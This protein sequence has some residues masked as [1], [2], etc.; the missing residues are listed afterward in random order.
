[1]FLACLHSI[2]LYAT[3]KYDFL[4]K[5]QTLSTSTFQSPRVWP[6]LFESPFSLIGTRELHVPESPKNFHMP[7]FE[8][9]E[10][11]TVDLSRNTCKANRC[12]YLCTKYEEK[13]LH[14]VLWNYAC[15]CVQYVA[16]SKFHSPTR[17]S[18]SASPCSHWSLDTS[19]QSGNRHPSKK[20]E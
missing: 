1:M 7:R 3:W 17:T 5:E 18:P 19:P 10:V 12:K 8:A 6:C 15:V 2:S 4:T 16:L 20:M 11:L 14:I 13:T 9:L